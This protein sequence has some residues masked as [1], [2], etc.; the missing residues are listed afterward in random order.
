MAVF[1]WTTGKSGDWNTATNWTPNTVPNDIAADVTID[2]APVT[3]G[4]YTVTIADG[5]TDTVNSLSINGTTNLDGSNATPYNAAA[6]ELDGT[7]A[8]AAGSAGLLD[9]SLQTFVH[10]AFGSNASMIN[11]GTVN[12]FIQVEGN[13]LVTGTNGFY[14]TNWMQ[15]LAGT[16]T[17]DTKTIAEMTG[18][19]LFDGIFEAKGQAD[20]PE[21]VINLGGS[22]Q[23]LVVNI[24]TIEGPPLIPDGWTEV[25]LNGPDGTSSI[26]EWTG[27]GYVG[28]ETT[29]KSIGSRG[30]VDVLGGRS[31]TTANALSVQTG[32][33]LNLAA[34]T[35]T[36]AEIDINGGTVQGFA[37]IAGNVVNAGTMTALGGKLTVG[38]T[39]SGNGVVNFDLDHK[40]GSINATGAT[41]EVHAVSA[42][43]TIV[44]NGD[45]TLVLDSPGAFAGTISAQVGDQIVLQ[46]ITATSAV[47]TNGML[48]ISN[49]SLVV[50]SLAL[51]G[52]YAAD[53]F[54]VTGGTIKVAAGATPTPTPTPTPKP[55]ATVPPIPPGTKVAG[56]DLTALDK[57]IQAARDSA[58]GAITLSQNAVLKVFTGVP[59]A[60]VTTF[61]NDI[62]TN[63]ATYRAAVTVVETNVVKMNTNDY[64]AVVKVI[65]QARLDMYS[66]RLQAVDGFNSSVRNLGEAY[67]LAHQK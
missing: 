34:G 39:L 62:A 45:D 2:A 37:A 5:V 50:A 24:A 26:N 36:A 8:F 56:I 27:T 25:L 4:V 6:F 63:I 3:P 66:A 58:I 42:T 53:H 22:K 9:G 51:T 1:S 20:G 57:D 23:G 14:V 61:K 48:V 65:N 18:N 49:G 44:M 59:A 15:A 7:L 17:V 41:L 12:G 40:T 60:D 28:I 43:Q 31:Y 64:A 38:G 11:A 32:G 16:V 35:F 46:G 52:S 67:R 54:D 33:M 19:T 47:D 21:A 30:T 13:L 29:L 10:T 55:T